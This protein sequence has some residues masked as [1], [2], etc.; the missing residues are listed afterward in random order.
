MKRNGFDFGDFEIT[1]R[2]ILASISIV[3]VMLLIGFVISGKISQSQVD[4]NEKYYKALKINNDKDIF[5][6]GMET[7]I[8]NAFIYGELKA[9]DTVTFSE[10]GGEYMYVEKVEERYERHERTV[11]KTDSNGKEH[12]ETEVYYTWDTEDSESLHSKELKFCGTTFP[13]SKIDVPYGSY[14]KTIPGSRTYSWKSGEFVKVR[15]VYYGT[16]TKFKGTMYTELKDKTISNNSSFYKD[17][18]ID[19]TVE[20]LE[21]SGVFA[22]VLF[23]IFWIILTGAAVFGFYYLD[24]E[25]LE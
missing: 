7:N 22:Q 19:E 20:Y 5:Q 2:E 4:K 13:Y 15:F 24:N 12:E 14:I 21:S 18:S 1:F 23:W 8:G 10:I 9:V 6:H 16:D 11:T 17:K 25:W 3:A